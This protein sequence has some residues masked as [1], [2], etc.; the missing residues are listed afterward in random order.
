MICKYSTQQYMETIIYIYL[1]R[2]TEKI[3]L[4]SKKFE[5]TS[6]KLI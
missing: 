5:Y 2:T 3:G 1:K 4:T 6:N